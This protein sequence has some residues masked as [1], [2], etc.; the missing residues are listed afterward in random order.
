MLLTNVDVVKVKDGLWYCFM[1]NGYQILSSKCICMTLNGIPDQKIFL[2]M[3]LLGQFVK[4]GH[5]CIYDLV[6]FYL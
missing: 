6:I 1:V 2:K 5:G 3:T 4:F